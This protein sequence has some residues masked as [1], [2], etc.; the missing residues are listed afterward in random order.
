[1]FG[2]VTEFPR[3]CVSRIIE[4][5]KEQGID[6][7]KSNAAEAFACLLTIAAWA[8]GRLSQED[9]VIFCDPEEEQLCADCCEALSVGLPAQAQP[10]GMPA[11][12]LSLVISRILA[13]LA[14]T[15]EVEKLLEQVLDWV[16]GNFNA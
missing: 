8:V 4:I 5:I 14:K 16:K 15:D 2:H 3:E 11:W 10:V 6:G 1:M 7:L 9:G 12:L 13:Q